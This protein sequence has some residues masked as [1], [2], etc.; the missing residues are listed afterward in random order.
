MEPA[1]MH[2]HPS[3]L[4]VVT[5]TVR[6]TVVCALSELGAATTSELREHTHASDRTLRRH[7]DAL[8]AIGVVEEQ[9]SESNGETPGRP[10][11]RFSLHPT[12]RRSTAALRELLAVPLEPW[13]R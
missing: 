5:D 6:L 11:G 4:D 7:L 1:Y 8:V 13:P 2:V 9:R 12:A 3:W 10:P